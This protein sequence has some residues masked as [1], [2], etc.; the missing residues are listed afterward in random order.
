MKKAL[1]ILSILKYVIRLDR[2]ARRAWIAEFRVGLHR[3]SRFRLDN[4][5]LPMWLTMALC[6]TPK[7]LQ[8]N[9]GTLLFA[10]AAMADPVGFEEE[11][12]EQ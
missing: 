1:D 8:W 6:P 5:G 12:E 2:D 7:Y 9:W 3:R 11:G 4:L 10:L